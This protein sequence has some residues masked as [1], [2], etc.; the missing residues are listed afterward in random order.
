MA[1]IRNW[2]VACGHFNVQK[3]CR[4]R[5]RRAFQ[6]KQEGSCRNLPSIQIAQVAWSFVE[7]QWRGFGYCHHS[8]Q[9][10]SLILSRRTP[11]TC[12]RSLDRKRS[13]AHSS[14]FIEKATN[15][16]YVTWFKRPLGTHQTSSIP[17]STLMRSRVEI[18]NTHYTSPLAGMA[19]RRIH[20]LLKGSVW[21]GSR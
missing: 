9:H 8:Q 5:T 19:A 7:R 3:D 20:L 4:L 14:M 1:L 6:A 15:C 12:C 13:I 2:M 11:V 16:P 17:R 21:A 10:Q 18:R